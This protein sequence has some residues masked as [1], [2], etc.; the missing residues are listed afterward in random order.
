MAG[1]QTTSG[2]KAATPTA[3]VLAWQARR[4]ATSRR[5]DW[6]EATMRRY[7]MPSLVDIAKRPGAVDRLSR[8]LDI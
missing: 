7:E 4:G 6:I 3:F 2:T 1:Y 8:L 5:A